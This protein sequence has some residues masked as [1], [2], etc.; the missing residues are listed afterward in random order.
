MTRSSRPVLYGS[1]WR[2]ADRLLRWPSSRGIGEETIPPPD[3]EG[4]RLRRDVTPETRRRGS[5][6]PYR[7]IPKS[8]IN[9]EIDR[10]PFNTNA[11]ASALD[12]SV[13][14]RRDPTNGLSC[15][16]IVMAHLVFKVSSQQAGPQNPKLEL[17][18]QTLRLDPNRQRHLQNQRRRVA[19]DITEASAAG[20]HGPHQIRDEPLPAGAPV[21]G[22]HV[23]RQGQQIGDV[24][25]GEKV[26]TEHLFG[27]HDRVI[28]GR[29]AIAVAA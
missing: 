9:R 24:L 11:G 12:S 16:I 14:R 23:D 13:N 18:S 25:S 5:P 3:L 2:L 10:S 28:Q 6:G 26:L 22:E 15:S 17:Q 1:F 8:R 7:L 19:I 4:N 29:I 27:L 21:V 20:S